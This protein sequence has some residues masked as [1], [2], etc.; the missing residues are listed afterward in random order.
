MNRVALDFNDGRWRDLLGYWTPY[1]PRAALRSFEQREGVDAW[2]ELW[3][4]LYHQGDI[5]EASY[6]AVR[7]WVRIYEEQGVPDCNTYSLVA[8]IEEARQ[9]GKN[10]NV[11]AY[12]C[13]RSKRLG[14]ALSGWHPRTQNR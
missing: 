12:L 6:A 2:Q 4:E 10:P 11:P 3:A 9:V 8:T 7:H 5:G 13:E 14:T 1:D